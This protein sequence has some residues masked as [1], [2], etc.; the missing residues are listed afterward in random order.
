MTT[1]AIFQFIGLLFTGSSILI[2]VHV[3]KRQM[4]AQLFVEYT[5]R[6]NEIMDPSTARRAMRNAADQE[7]P[8]TDPEITLVVLK[9][10]NLCSEEFYLMKRGYL[11]KDIWNIWEAEIKLTLCGPLYRREWQTLSKEFLGF[12][13]FAAWVNDLHQLSTANQTTTAG[14]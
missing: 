9:Y 11:S 8:A 14:I 3:Y 4:N 2:A 7:L 1:D 5:Q 10:L 13:E 12:S 6:Y